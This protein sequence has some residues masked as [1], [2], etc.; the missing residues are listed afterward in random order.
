MFT[1]IF[2]LF[3]GMLE[4]SQGDGVKVLSVSNKAPGKY[5]WAVIGDD[6]YAARDCYKVVSGK[7]IDYQYFENI[8]IKLSNINTH[9][10]KQLHIHEIVA[11]R[12]TRVLNPY[13]GYASYRY[14]WNG[15]LVPDGRYA[16]SIEHNGAV[17][18]VNILLK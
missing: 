13:Y 2:F 12:D 14:S 17:S 10:F 11:R 4:K 9:I 7:C 6:E 3:K 1:G 15:S 16:I 8:G 18:G 5:S